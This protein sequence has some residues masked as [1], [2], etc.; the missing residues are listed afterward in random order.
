MTYFEI[1][2]MVIC[3]IL[4]KGHDLSLLHI[5]DN[6]IH[7]TILLFHNTYLLLYGNMY[8]IFSGIIAGLEYNASMKD[9]MEYL[10]S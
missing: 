6:N 1:H 2:A 9:N 8:N 3:R 4:G 10:G 5:N 7:K